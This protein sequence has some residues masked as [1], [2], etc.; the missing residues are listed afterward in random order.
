MVSIIPS[1][2]HSIRKRMVSN[3]YSKSYILSSPHLQAISQTII[4]DRF[5]PVIQTLGSKKTLDVL[6]PF[7]AVNMDLMS[8]YLFGLNNGTNFLQD[9]KT[10]KHWLSIYQD[11]KQHIF[12]QP[13]LPNLVAW[14][15]RIGIRI[16]PRQFDTASK[17]IETWC[18]SMCDAAE[19]SLAT[20]SATGSQDLKSEPVVYKQLK[21]GLGNH[22]SDP[23][24]NLPSLNHRLS[25]ASEML[26]SLIAG[27][28]TSGITL[29]YLTHALSLRPHL[30]SLL[31]NELLTLS[32]QLLFPHSNQTQAPASLPPPKAIDTLPLLHAII[33]ETLRLHPPVP[34]GQPRVTP[35]S[36][37]TTLGGYTDIPPG[38]RVNAQAYSLHRNADVFPEP[39]EW[40]PERWMESKKEA[41]GGRDEK[42]RWFWAF[43]SGGRMC[44]GSN[45]AIHGTYSLSFFEPG[46]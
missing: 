2:P 16:V 11:R 23:P 45:F 27:F 39:E 31:R 41:E 7:Y 1:K 17:E 26:D 33:M 24:P 12:W 3:I 35:S 22:H 19:R 42:S 20:L 44:V 28:E 37:T 34:I 10:R 6:Q 43:S 32:P 9:E 15:A 8:G 29:T 5:L 38:T 36:G 4:Y 30:Q 14:L 40:R 46:G 25:I 21:H 18:L 13:E